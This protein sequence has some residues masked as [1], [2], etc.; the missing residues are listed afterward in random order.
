MYLDESKKAGDVLLQALNEEIV[1]RYRR[2]VLHDQTQDRFHCSEAD[3]DRKRRVYIECDDNTSDLAFK[4]ELKALLESSGF[5][6]WDN[7]RSGRSH[8]ENLDLA[9]KESQWSIFL[10]SKESTES[11]NFPLLNLKCR[12]VLH[13]SVQNNE[14]CVIPI[15]DH[16]DG[17]E[18]LYELGW[19]T[20][21]NRHDENF[22]ER[23]LQ[24][25]RRK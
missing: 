18:L 11:S 8:A 17:S 7:D 4:A 25:L 5:L 3:K 12:T 15:L 9:T 10:L 2:P 23:L 14:M 16:I 19:V 6:V 21:L 13:E 24:T 1:K 20:Y 22:Q